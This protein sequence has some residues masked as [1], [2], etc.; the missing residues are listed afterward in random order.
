MP[1]KDVMPKFYHGTLHSGSGHKVT[2]LEQA[3]AIAHSEHAKEK[4]HGGHYPEGHKG[5]KKKKSMGEALRG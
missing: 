5:K 4:K 2:N 3:L 1:S